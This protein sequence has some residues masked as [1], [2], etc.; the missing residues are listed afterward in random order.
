V[1][2]KKCLLILAAAACVARGQGTPAQGGVDSEWDIR[3]LLASLASEASRL[4]PIL[5]QSDPKKW[6]DASAAQSYGSQWQ[7]AQSEI[8]YLA[9]ST[10]LFSK[11][12]ER[13]TLALETFF[14]LESLELTLSSYREGLSRYGNPAVAEL[15]QGTVRE[16]SNNRERLRRYISELAQTKEQEFQIADKEAQRCRTNLSKQP[17]ER[18]SKNRSNR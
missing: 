12:P 6:K 16:N 15:L 10:D 3:K 8:Q 7:S 11:Q 18:A 14:R 9:R 4:K 13:L 5:D 17:P 2:V 1:F